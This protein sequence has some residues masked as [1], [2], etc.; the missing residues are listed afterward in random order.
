VERW[1]IVAAVAALILVPS[2]ADARAFPLVSGQTAVGDIGEHVTVYKD[3]LLDIA[4]DN[5]LG[6]TQLV[7]ANRGVDPWLPGANKHVVLPQFYL[8][9]D[10]PRRGIVINLAQQ[11]AYYYPHGGKIV[12]TFPIG[13][14]VQGWIT[15]I[16]TTRVI[17]KTVHPG[18]SPPASIRAEKPELPK[19][20]PPGPDNPLGDYA[21]ALG[22]HSYLLHGTDKPFGVGRNVSHGCIRFYPEDIDHLF[23]E[24]PVGTSV[25]VI[26]EEVVASWVG[27]RLYVAVF[28]NKQQTDDIDIEQPMKRELPDNLVQR[29]RDVAGDRADQVDW[30]LVTRLGLERTGVP[31]VVMPASVADAAPSDVTPISAAHPVASLPAR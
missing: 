24:V 30:A 21:M 8:L 14:G 12:E 7:I 18:W 29:V 20:V 1:R 17:S 3:T 23:H 16:G 13:V 28:P 4:R 2:L 6:Y 26:N 22:W 11:R 9:P 10:G 31:T 19:Y 15:P 27:E 25:R 5:D